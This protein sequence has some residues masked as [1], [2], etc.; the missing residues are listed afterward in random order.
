MLCIYNT[1]EHISTIICIYIYIHT[2]IYICIYIYIY[3]QTYIYIYICIYIYI[4]IYIHIYIYIYIYICVYIEYICP[5]PLYHI[6]VLPGHFFQTCCAMLYT[7]RRI[8]GQM[9]SY[10]S[11][12]MYMPRPEAKEQ[13]KRHLKTSVK[14]IILH[15]FIYNIK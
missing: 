1:Y 6:P 5:M 10:V 13:L 9:P 11:V 15:I 2:Y 4:Y 8:N 14:Y 7:H 3:I 12:C